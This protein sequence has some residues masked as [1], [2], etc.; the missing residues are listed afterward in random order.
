[1]ARQDSDQGTWIG[2]VEEVS[3]SSMYLHLQVPKILWIGAN[4]TSDDDDDSRPR[5]GWIGGSP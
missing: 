1:M 2:T 5:V 4:G 3:H